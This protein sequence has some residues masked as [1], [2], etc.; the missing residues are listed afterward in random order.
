MS[1]DYEGGAT[2]VGPEE[3]FKG[4]HAQVHRRKGLVYAQFDKGKVWECFSRL[5]FAAADWDFDG[6][7]E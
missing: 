6:E 3:Q 7:D 5:T 2:Y 4:R 1:V